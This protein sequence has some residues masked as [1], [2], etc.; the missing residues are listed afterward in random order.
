MNLFIIGLVLF[1][2][3]HVVPELPG[4]RDAL[5]KQFSEKGFK[6]LFAII[7]L[8]GLVLIVWGFHKAPHVEMF[9]PAA[10]AK[11][12]AILLMPF[13]LILLASAH[14]KGRIRLALRHPMMIG[15][16]L[17]AAVHMI[18]NGDRNGLILFGA[19]LV[20]SIISIWSANRRG[21]AAGYAPVS[22]KDISAVIAGIVV[23]AI[24]LFAHPFLFGA[25]IF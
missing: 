10:W 7:S 17:W 2:G 19:F 23:Y 21:P 25:K 22:R 5:V 20:Y 24:L 9:E 11:W 6:G 13:V 8:V 1:F 16:G 3:M 4:L 12:P 15:V 14:M 18:A